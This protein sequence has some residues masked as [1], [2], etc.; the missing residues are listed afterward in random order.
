M[1][2]ESFDEKAEN[3]VVE[4]DEIVT[5][6]NAENAEEKPVADEGAENVQEDAILTENALNMPETN[7]QKAK[8]VIKKYF[9][10]YF[11]DAFTGM[12]QGLFC[13]LIAGTILAQ[14][15]SWCGDNAFAHTLNYIASI[16]KMLMGAGIGVGIA[17]K[18]G[19]KPLVIFTAAVT[20]LVGAW[21]GNLVNSL[22]TGAA[23][24]LA[25][26]AP[27]NPIGSYVVALLTIEI[28][29]LYAGKTKVDIVLVPL[30]MMALTLA[31]IFIAWPFIKLIELLGIG[32]A[33]A[34]EAGAAVKIIIGIF[35]AIVMGILLTMPTSS[36][37]IWIAITVAVSAEYQ[38][39][40]EIAGGAAV[41]GCAAHMVGFAVASFRE[42][43]FG[44]LISQ[45]IGTSM[46][47]I[48]NI[49][50]H[51][52]II[53]PEIVASAVSGLVAVLLGLRCNAAGGGMGTSGLVGVFGTIEAS[54]NAG[55]ETWKLVLGIILCLFV[56]PAV[57]SFAVSEL[58]RKKNL[59]K[60]G[61]QQ[62]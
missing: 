15:A 37:A 44:G 55:L 62:L 6:N 28:A 27:G 50:K 13:T 31:G 1:V 36:A 35:V 47:Q 23:F 22:T 40:L 49:M 56:I 42:N 8:R 2:E 39:A 41:A 19:A 29:G 61:D 25:L 4:D 57:V 53:V 18:L 11:I 20:G 38:D 32:I 45:G 43:K 7:K 3:S 14:I 12:A 60:P 30:G 5:E 54:M 16:A 21:A 17:S 33:L 24:A 10:R 46:L 34:I 59:I 52:I 26:G 51:P 9:N 58:L 48:P